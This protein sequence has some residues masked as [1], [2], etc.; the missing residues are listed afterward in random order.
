MGRIQPVSPA[1]E[2]S[3]PGRPVSLWDIMLKLAA[4]EFGRG[5]AD[6]LLLEKTCERLAKEPGLLAAAGMSEKQLFL[7]HATNVFGN[8]KRVCILSDLDDILPQ[9]DRIAR[10]IHT[11]DA[12][13][14][15]ASAEHLR[16]RLYDEL[17]NEFYLQLVRSDV[18][19]YGKKELFGPEVAK[20]FKD[21]SGD[22]ENAGNCLALRQPDACVFHLM[23]AMEI[24]VR[25]L[26]KRL[27]VTITPQ[28]T[29]RH[30]T[31]LMDDKI[32]KLPENTH[33]LK[34]KKN[35]WEGARANLHLVGSVW[36][37]N[38]MHPATSYT[39][40]Q[41]RDVFNAVRVFMVAL[42]AL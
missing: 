32:K 37:N 2:D 28:T 7:E 34:Q 29:W 26:S 20:K 16:M 3:A 22:I 9:I 42:A 13:A 39:P 10:V 6:L 18:P 5:L 14:V 41:A 30:L 21:A 35:D 23:R 8:L 40:S 17:K 31:G 19:F 4:L 25:Q 33:R 27:K 24:A 38:T 12:A 36:R 11:F 15:K 1:F